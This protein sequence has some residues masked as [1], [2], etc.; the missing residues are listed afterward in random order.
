MLGKRILI[1]MVTLFTVLMPVLSVCGNTGKIEGRVVERKTKERLP[2]VNISVKGTT[3][4]AATDK[5][6]NYFIAGIPAGKYQV[7]ASMIGFRS[8][9][10]SVEVYADSISVLDFE[11]SPTAIEGEGVVVT[12]TRTERLLK[13]VPVYTEVITGKKIEVKNADNLRDALKGEVGI[14]VKT[15]CPRCNAAEIQIQGLP[16]RY[17]QVLID[18]MPVVSDLGALYGLAHIPSENIERIEIVKG[19]GSAIYGSDAI[20]GVVNVITKSQETTSGDVSVTSGYFG[21][22][23]LMSTLGTKMGN[24]EATATVSKS[25]ADAVDVDDDGIAD[26]VQSDRTAGSVKLKHQLVSNTTMTISGNFRTEDRLGGSIER[27]L[28]KTGTGAYVN[29]N[30]N[31][32][33]LGGSLEWDPT[34]ISSLVLRGVSSCYDQRVFVEETWYKASEDIVFGE[35]QYTRYLTSKHLFSTGISHKY[36]CVEEN[37][38]IGIKKANSSGIYI[39]DE[40][41]YS[42]VNFVLGTRYD[43]HSEFGSYVSPRAAIMYEPVHGLTLRSSYG[44]GFKAPT[45]FFK[46]MHFCAAE[47]MYEFV[48]NPDIAPEKSRSANFSTEYRTGIFSIGM[49]L[50]Q[51]DVKDMIQEDLIEIDSAAGIWRY[52]YINIGEALT[53]GVELNGSLELLQGLSLKLGYSYLDARDKTT[54]TPLLFRSK[55]SGNWNLRY[56]NHTVGIEINLSGEFTGSMPVQIGTDEG[57]DSPSYTVWNCKVSQRIGSSYTFFIGADNIFDYAQRESIQGGVTL[58]GPT[59]GRYLYGG[60]KLNF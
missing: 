45:V 42:P 53:R 6:G 59:R 18:G 12:A 36:E 21:A 11:L 50:F 54:D 29:P 7:Y 56:E 51:T 22:Q 43:Y 19:A 16:G 47:A 23:S 37:T 14:G 10:K 24:L 31:Q 34:D 35:A 15:L 44:F 32:Y 57:F 58:W 52:Q 1:V 25:K 8:M 55:H 17:T 20:A 4:G 40:I 5:D 48:P 30:I 13:D 49:N 9:T 60:V 2:I 39:Q 33:D 46:Q 27:I 41:D 38:R 26:Y 3:L 28:G